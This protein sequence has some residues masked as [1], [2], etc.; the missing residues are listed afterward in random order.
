MQTKTR[1][2]RQLGAMDYYGLRWESRPHW[3]QPDEH[4]VPHCSQKPACRTATTVPALDLGVNSA[5]LVCGMKRTE[6]DKR[7]W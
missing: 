4:C 7:I 3:A 2:Q 6:I 5:V 1:R